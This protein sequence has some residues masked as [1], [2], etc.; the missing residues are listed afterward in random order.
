[1]IYV[2]SFFKREE[3]GRNM[4]LDRGLYWFQVSFSSFFCR[5]EGRED[6][7]VIIRY[8]G[9]RIKLKR[10]LDTFIRQ[11]EI[12]YKNGVMDNKWIIF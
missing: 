11:R 5:R 3:S 1:M 10:I 6:L 8:L 4:G 2:I 9:S 7:V 12:K